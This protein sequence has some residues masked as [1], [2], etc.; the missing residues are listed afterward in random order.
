MC[1]EKL[2]DKMKILKNLKIAS[3]GSVNFAEKPIKASGLISF[4]L[5]DD[6]NCSVYQKIKKTS[7]DLK[8][9][10]LYKKKYLK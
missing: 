4:Q 5:Q 7:M 8:H 1:L 2:I 6:K 10:Q 9:L 3:D